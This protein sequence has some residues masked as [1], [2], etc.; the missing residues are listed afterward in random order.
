MTQ[1]APVSDQI[2]LDYH[3][4]RECIAMVAGILTHWL[5]GH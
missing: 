5:Q 4:D 1:R 3:L 2:M